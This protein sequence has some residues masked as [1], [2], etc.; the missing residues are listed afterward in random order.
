[1]SKDQATETKPDEPKVNIYMVFLGGR[2]VDKKRH[3]YWAEIEPDQNNG[4]RFKPKPEHTH[5][6]SGKNVL[7]SALPGAVITIDARPDRKSVWPGS[8]KLVGSWENAE[9][10]AEWNGLHRAT[11]REIEAEG[12]I[13][14]QIRASLPSASLAPFRRAYQRAKNA[15]QRAHI[16]AWVIEEI[17]RYEHG[18]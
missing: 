7:K 1:M 2:R 18:S 8:A 10:V 15:R 12:K 5:S 4:E 9:D 13:G 11:D 14:K 16:L 3:W 6:Y 17:T